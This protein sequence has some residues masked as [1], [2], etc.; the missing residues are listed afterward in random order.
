M[1][2]A[3]PNRHQKRKARGGIRCSLISARTFRLANL[4]RWGGED[5]RAGRYGWELHAEEFAVS[6]WGR[7]MLPLV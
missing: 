5:L 7:D 1:R 2:R 4:L 6:S 3:R